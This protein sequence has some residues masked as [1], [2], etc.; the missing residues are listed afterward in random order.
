ML[1]LGVLVAATTVNDMATLD[2]WLGRCEGVLDQEAVEEA[3]LQT[4]LFAGYPKTIEALKQVRKHFPQTGSEKHVN[5]HLTAGNATSKI[6]YGGY[7][8]RLIE[9]MDE[10]HPDLTRWMI[11]DG[12][13][14]VLSRPGLS[15]PEREIGVLASLMASGMV[16]QYR[17]HLRGALFAGITP[18]DIIWFINT[19]QCIIVA[20]LRTAFEKVT[21][22]MLTMPKTR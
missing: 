18:D 17:A 7:H 21:N 13:G 10:L 19:F 8:P 5:N 9:V 4:L 20:D 22:Q 6:I 12:Y 1:L 11:E 3:I 2:E 15:L 14:R 16:N